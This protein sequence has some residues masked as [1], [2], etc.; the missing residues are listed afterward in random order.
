MNTVK[1][2]AGGWVTIGRRGENGRTTVL[3]DVTVRFQTVKRA[4][5]RC[6]PNVQKLG[7]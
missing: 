1:A 6:T 2:E 5:K 4:I 7:L 3:F